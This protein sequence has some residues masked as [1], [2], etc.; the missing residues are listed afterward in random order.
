MVRFSFF[1]V[2]LKEKWIEGKLS[3]PIMLEPPRIAKF[4]IHHR[5]VTSDL[6]EAVEDWQLKTWGGWWIGG[7][8]VIP[9]PMQLCT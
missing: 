4:T 3:T 9:F 2:S 1:N 5:A 7:M 8:L 6:S